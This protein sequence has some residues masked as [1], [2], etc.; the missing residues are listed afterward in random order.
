MT[1]SKSPRPLPLAHKG[2][3]GKGAGCNY[4]VSLSAYLFLKS[5]ESS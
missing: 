4:W 1:K 5:S 3:G 2:V